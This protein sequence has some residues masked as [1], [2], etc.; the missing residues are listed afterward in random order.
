M[1]G[2]YDE[3]G[4]LPGELEDVVQTIGNRNYKKDALHLYFYAKKF[5]N[6]QKFCDTVIITLLWWL[7]I[8]QI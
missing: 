5:L 6:V 3:K 2:A 4:I 8:W 7:Q 1:R